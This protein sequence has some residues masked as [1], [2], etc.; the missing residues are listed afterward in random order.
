[1][2]I[3]HMNLCSA[4]NFFNTTE[5]MNEYVLNKRVLLDIV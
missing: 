3:D 5:Q 1:M 2:P 4:G